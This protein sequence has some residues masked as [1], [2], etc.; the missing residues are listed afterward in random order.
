MARPWTSARQTC[1]RQ[2]ALLVDS[3]AASAMCHDEF[4]CV[5]FLSYPSDQSVSA[6]MPLCNSCASFHVY[7]SLVAS[8]AAVNTV[9]T[10][11]KVKSCKAV[12]QTKKQSSTSFNKMED[13]LLPQ[14]KKDITELKATQQRKTAT[15]AF[16]MPACIFE[17]DRNTGQMKTTEVVQG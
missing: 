10:H 3:A 1:A 13:M 12:N 2:H 11:F 14:P 5:D 8:A 15:Q 7:I 16:T 9:S 6:S 17:L 4:P